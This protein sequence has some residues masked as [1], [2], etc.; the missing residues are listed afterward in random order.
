MIGALA[1]SALSLVSTGF[2]QANGRTFDQLALYGHSTYA[3]AQ[4]SVDPVANEFSMGWLGVEENK[5]NGSDLIQVGWWYWQ[6][7]HETVPFIQVWS[8]GQEVINRNLPYTLVS[9]GT[10]M[11]AIS[12]TPGTDQWSVWAQENGVW[13]DVQNFTSDLNTNSVESVWQVD[14]ETTTTGIT[15]ALDEGVGTGTGVFAPYAWYNG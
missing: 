12:Q 9:G 6:Q 5:G 11:V 14:T 4:L 3:E 1:L 13:V 8:H 2:L 15:P 10:Q 7:G